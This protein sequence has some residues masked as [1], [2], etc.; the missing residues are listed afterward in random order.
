MT[1]IEIKELPRMN[2]AKI[3]YYIDTKS[4]SRRKLAK[5]LGIHVTTLSV[6]INNNESLVDFKLGTVKNLQVKIAKKLGVELN[7]IT[8]GGGDEKL[9]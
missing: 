4:I 2:P 6:I 8:R 7:D 1:E 3:R 5:E 9:E